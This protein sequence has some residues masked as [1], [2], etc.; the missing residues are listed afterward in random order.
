MSCVRYSSGTSL[1][2]WNTVAP[3]DSNSAPLAEGTHAPG[4]ALLDHPENLGKGAPC[5]AAARFCGAWPA[6]PLSRGSN[7]MSAASTSS[8]KPR[9][10]YN[11]VDVGLSRSAYSVQKSLPRS[12]A[13][14][15]RRATALPA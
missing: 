9:R 4:Q 2:F 13:I 1:M 15:Q 12:K 7:A 10:R 11:P 6:H 5:E 14:R 3:S 8:S